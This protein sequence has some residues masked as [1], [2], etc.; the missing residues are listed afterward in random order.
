M[1]INLRL[2]PLKNKFTIWRE[3]ILFGC[4]ARGRRILTLDSEFKQLSPLR[5][6]SDS[7]L[8]P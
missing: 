8:S 5:P 6:I 3:R 2:G 7:L 4:K 1:N